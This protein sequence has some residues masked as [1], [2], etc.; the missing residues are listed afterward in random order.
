[1][2]E[3]STNAELEQR[4][5]QAQAHRLCLRRYSLAM[6][7]IGLVVAVLLYL[8]SRA[9]NYNIF[10]SIVDGATVFIAGSVFLVVWNGRRHL[11][12]HY[13]LFIAIAFLA[14]ALLDFAHLL[15]N[16]DMG[17]F[18]GYDNLGPTFY[19]ASR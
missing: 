12:N 6:A 4:P 18:P 16:K 9:A 8:V 10:H 11:D 17:V 2:S 1:M 15:G 5:P 7:P 3:K 19:I 13:Y 14:F